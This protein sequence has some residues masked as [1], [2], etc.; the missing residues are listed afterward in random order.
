MPMVPADWTANRSTLEI[1]YIGSDHGGSP[2][3]SYATVIQF[4]RFW[5]G[6]AD[7]SSYGGSDDQ[8]DAT[9]V[10]PSTR[11]TDNI[12]TLINGWWISQATSEHLYDGSIINTFGDP[13]IF[14]GIVNFGNADVQIQIHQD[15]AVLQDDWWNL[16]G[17]GLNADATQ[18]I[19]HRFMLPVRSGSPATDIDLRRVL[20]T[21]RRFNFTYSE[22]SI[23]ATARGNNVLALSDASDLNNQTAAGTVATWTGVS[24]TT[25]G[26]NL[27]DVDLLGADPFYSEWNTDQPTRTINEFTERLKWLTRDGAAND[28]P[29][30]LLYGLDPELF[31]GITHELDVDGGAGTFGTPEFEPIS[32]DTGTGQL[33][34]VDDKTGS[35]TTIIW[36]QLLTGTVPTDN[37][38]ITGGTS[39]A[40]VVAE[41]AGGSLT[42]RTIST[43]FFGVSTGTALIGSYGLGVETLDLSSTDS[44]TH[45][46]DVVVNPPNNVTFTVAGIVHNE[47][48]VLV[49]PWDGSSLDVNGDPAVHESFLRL[50][51]TLSGASETA[52]VCTAAIPTWLPAS[53]TIRIENDEGLRR[54]VTYDSYTGSTFTIPATAFNGSGETDSAT[55]GSPSKNIYPSF[56]DTLNNFSPEQTSISF[57]GVNNSDRDL[58]VMVRDGGGTPIK[59]YIATAIFG[60]ANSTTTAIRTSDE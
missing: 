2:V 48:H 21:A 6:L 57:T 34:A 54:R 45:L 39:G 42:P 30:I 59:Q 8:I 50:N 31:R 25:E 37:D 17:A 13:Q 23:N 4:H 12:I 18:G 33:L 16:A 53:G 52:V 38:T 60:S 51:T 5:Q 11:A 28:S 36:F 7:D 46:G 20:G 32:W 47:D 14:D 24:N 27:L 56:I 3:A 29:H 40:T 10:L 22:F 19:S 1:A 26:Y 43:P 55:V 35:S 15:G 44:V 9:V 49:T 58:V 41:L